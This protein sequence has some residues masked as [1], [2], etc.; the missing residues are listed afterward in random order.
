MKSNTKNKNLL[1]LV[2]SAISPVKKSIKYG[3]LI[4]ANIIAICESVRL[5]FT[6]TIG[7]KINHR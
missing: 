3:A 1:L 2:L 4:T 7:I 6:E 5:S